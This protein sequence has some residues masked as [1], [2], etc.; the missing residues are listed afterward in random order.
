MFLTADEIEEVTG[1][2]Q[3]SLQIEFLRARRIRHIVNRAG[4]PV[5]ARAWIIG[6]RDVVVALER[7]NLAALKRA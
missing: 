3:R 4:R 1:T 6:D 7:P 5:I 2:P